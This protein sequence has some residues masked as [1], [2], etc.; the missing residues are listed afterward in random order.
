MPSARAEIV[1][2]DGSTLILDGRRALGQ[3]VCTLATDLAAE[4]ALAHGVAAVAVRHSGHAGRFAD[5]ADRACEQGAALLVFANDSGAGQAVA[6]PGGLEGRLSTNPLA[7]GV[8]RTKPPHLVIDLATSVAAQGK[9]RV[10]QDAGRPVPE[11][12]VRDGLL[13]PLGGA[14]GFALALLVEALAGVVSGAGAV[15][16]DPGPDDQGVFLLA[17]DPGRFGDPAELAGR[18]DA[19]LAHV[20][21]APVRE[22]AEPLRAPGSGLPPLPLD[23]DGALRARSRDAGAAR[24]AGG[25]TR[26]SR[27]RLTGLPRNGSHVAGVTC[28]YP[29]GWAPVPLP[30][31]TAISHFCEPSST[32]PTRASSPR[33]QMARSCS[34]TRFSS[35]TTAVRGP[36]RAR[37]NGSGAASTSRTTASRRWPATTRR[38]R[39]SYAATSSAA[40]ST[41]S[42]APTASCGTGA[43]GERRSSATTAGCTGPCW[44]STT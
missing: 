3:V 41:P 29:A 40:S 8:P 17:F 12:W 7:A 44:R 27:P 16:P 28:R 9:V 25:R 34:G 26:S 4:R 15:G 6:P 32:M 18:V 31:A 42:S 11:A 14:K 43:P 38:S 20:L 13:Q 23:P 37:M 30:A 10:L 2:D 35:A 5:Y 22:G 1:R 24:R 36:V 33:T 21:S 39:V 19:M